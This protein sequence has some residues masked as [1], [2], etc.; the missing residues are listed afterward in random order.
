MAV[1]RKVFFMNNTINIKQ[2]VNI[3]NGR[4]VT[5]VK[6]GKDEEPGEFYTGAVEQ[7]DNLF[8]MMEELKQ[9]FGRTIV[10]QQIVDEVKEGE[11]LIGL[12][13]DSI[14]NGDNVSVKMDTDSVKGSVT[15][16]KL[17]SIGGLSRVVVSQTFNNIEAGSKVVGGVFDSL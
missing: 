15:G 6:I 8:N 5:S 13:L 9:K 14:G 1:R 12:K 11:S 17:D 4:Q 2:T 7:K 16:L 10:V 3:V